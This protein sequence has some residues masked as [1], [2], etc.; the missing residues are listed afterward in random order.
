VPA[1]GIHDL[2]RRDLVERILQGVAQTTIENRL[3]MELVSVI[4]WGRRWSIPPQPSV[5]NHD[6]V[7]TTND[8]DE[9]QTVTSR[10]QRHELC[11]RCAV[12]G[13]HNYVQ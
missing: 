6:A 12:W 8:Q 2:H 11:I 13:V 4:T 3:H 5:V 7:H 1:L 9:D 10:C